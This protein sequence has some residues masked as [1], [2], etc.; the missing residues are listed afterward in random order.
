MDRWKRREGERGRK[1]D[2]EIRK[3]ERNREI[4]KRECFF[5]LFFFF[6][7][8]GGRENSDRQR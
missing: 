2:G 1:K 8:G 6:W 4:G 5:F 7:G 3:R